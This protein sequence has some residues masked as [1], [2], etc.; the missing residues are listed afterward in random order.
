MNPPTLLRKI[1]LSNT[2]AETARDFLRREWLLTNGLGGYASGTISGMVS[3]RY[4][5][6]LVAALPAP[7]GRI[8][9]LNHLAEYL[10]PTESRQLQFGGDEKCGPDTPDEKCHFIREFRL[11]DGLPVW[12]YE[13]EGHVVERSILLVHGQNTVHITYRLL[14]GQDTL[15]LELAPA[16]HFRPHEND[17]GGSLGEGYTLN[18][19]NHHYEV[20]GPAPF[21]PVRMIVQDGSAAFTHAGTFRSEISYQMEAERGYRSLGS[22]W[23]PGNFLIELRPHGSVTLVAST[24]PWNSVLALTPSEAFASERERRRRL[25]A[26]AP[27]ETQQGEA[28]ELVLAADQFII[29]PAGRVE[30]AARARAA[31]DEVRTVIAGYHWF[32]DWGRDTMISL[33]GLTLLTG[34]QVEAGWILRTFAHYIRDG[35]IPNMFPESESEGLYHTADA[36]LWFFHALERYLEASGDRTTLVILLPKLVEIVEKHLHGTRFGIHV[37]PKDGLLRQGA[38]GYQLTWMDAK[39]EDWVVTPRRGKAVEINALWYN[40]L[41]LLERWLREENRIA[42]ADAYAR[43]AEQVRTA[44]N[45]RFWSDELGYLFDV[46][47]GEQGDDPACRPNQIFAISLPHPVLA[48]ERWPAVLE[49]VRGELLTPVGLRSL[50]RGHPDYK[51]RYFGDLRA[52]DAAYHQG[53][54]WGWLIGPFIDAWLKVHPEDRSGARQFLSGLLAHLSTACIGSMSEIFDAE[55]PFTPRGCIAQAWTVAEVL[56]CWVKTGE[57]KS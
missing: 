40:A 43:N 34:R 42:E 50:S 49:K 17:V 33:E 35:L 15:R 38:E 56:R 39:V 57:K 46:V 16:F 1:D 31:G 11:E 21:P 8:V 3:R 32:T 13:I 19:H 29:S 48:P 51:S 36:T 28:A 30:D 44:F 37:D 25:I 5:G 55:E 54:V 23:I 53:T 24:E 10:Y 22:L 9:M 14:T 20:Q 2:R 18:I 47:D 27:P 6:L 4:H 7:L 45:Q 26:A 41:R 52:R 12:R